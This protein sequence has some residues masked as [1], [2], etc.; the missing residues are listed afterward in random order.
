MLIFL[1]NPN[2]LGCGRT[3]SAREED[4]WLFGNRDPVSLHL[5][6]LDLKVVNLGNELG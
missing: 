3:H 1:R 2:R 5:V 4:L 6:N